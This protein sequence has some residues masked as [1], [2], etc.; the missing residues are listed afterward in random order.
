MPNARKLDEEVMLQAQV[1]MIVAGQ[2]KRKVQMEANAVILRAAV[3]NLM[4]SCMNDQLGDE[5]RL[6][7][8][9]PK[10]PAKAI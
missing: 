5:A 9:G 8:N 7:A 4:N 2:R 1:I 10:I 3:G 6:G